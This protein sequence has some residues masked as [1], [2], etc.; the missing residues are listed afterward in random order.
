MEILD[1]P[2]SPDE[3]SMSGTYL[4]KEL[5]DQFK[6]QRQH[7]I[8]TPAAHPFIFLFTDIETEEYG[9]SDQ[10]LDNG[11]FVY[12]GEGQRGNMTMD[13]GNRRILEHEKNGDSLYVFERVDEVNGADVV[14]FD[15]EYEYIDHHWEKA[16]DDDGIMREA[17]RFKL[18]PVGGV[19]A[20]L[21]EDQ[22]DQLSLE[23]LFQKAEENASHSNPNH[24][25]ST[26]GTTGSSSY[27]TSELV[28]DCALRAADSV[29]QGCENEAPFVD[30]KGEPSLEVHHMHRRS[31]GGLDVPE[32]V[33]AICP[34]CHRE[35]HYG[36]TGN[37]LNEQ[38]IQKAAARNRCFS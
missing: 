8:S 10:F 37:E 15:G 6:G 23:E 25:G 11:L 31:D 18:A 35:V 36:K 1:V 9:Y 3:F 17:L 13:G 26:S 12:S 22:A 19:G 28:R 38:L 4:R 20:D 7:G 2:A 21:T 27:T 24:S 29:C 34:N 33:I 32:N 5:H 14:T 30:K 16:P